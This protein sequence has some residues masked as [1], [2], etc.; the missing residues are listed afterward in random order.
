MST[1]DRKLL[2]SGASGQLGRRVVELLLEAN[3]GPV[4]ALTRSPEKLADLAARGVEVRR[5]DFAD[6]ASL[7]QAFAGATR[8]LI[9]S[10]DA[11]DKPRAPQHV[12]AV[13]AAVRAGVKHV[14]YTSL[15]N[16]GAD[17]PI[18]IAE[19]HRLTEEALRK[20]GVGY[21]ALRNNMYAEMLLMS[22]PRAVATGQLA[23]AAGDGGVGYV[24]R[25]DCA[26]AA[27]A[28]LVQGDDA[29]RRALDITGPEVVTHAQLAQLASQL[30]GKPVQYVPVPI[31]AIE[32]G[33]QQAGLP[34]PIAKALASFDT[35]IAKGT[36][37]VATDTVETLTGRTPTSVEA[38]LR[39]HLGALTGPA[40]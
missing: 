32:Q 12:A 22:L 20:S 17:S 19:D 27:A 21:T 6:P 36:L 34:A 9:I 23:A 30:T 29:D 10:I 2:V 28:A 5:A 13:E 15:T 11:L 26:R 18:L 31:E 38:F 14:V 24:T 1:T 16:P 37:A 3:A 7:D 4:I 8:A 35:G 25:E 33:M 39:A 40:A